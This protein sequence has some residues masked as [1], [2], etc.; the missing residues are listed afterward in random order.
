MAIDKTF[1]GPGEMDG[2]DGGSSQGLLSP[3]ALLELLSF[4]PHPEAQRTLQAP[5]SKVYLSS[6]TL[7]ENIWKAR[8]VEQWKVP[9]NTTCHAWRTLHIDLVHRLS[10]VDGTAEETCGGGDYD[11]VVAIVQVLDAYRTLAEMTRACFDRLGHLLNSEEAREA[12]KCVDWRIMDHALWAL[13]TYPDD[14]DL[15]LKIL[16]FL[17]L[18]GRPAGRVEG[19]VMCRP[20]ASDGSLRAFGPSGDGIEAVLACMERHR[21][22]AAVQAVACWSLVNLALIPGQKRS[23]CRQ[24]GVLAIVRAMA[25]HPQ[26]SEV[27]FRAMFALI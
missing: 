16:R 1:V 4:L 25:R 3:D 12:V 27:H 26:D 9:P 10:L 19:A 17:V 11:N 5:L 8:C 18:A 14:V 6:F 23:L 2:G 24:G 22:N 21:S 13:K 7:E 15:L 20:P